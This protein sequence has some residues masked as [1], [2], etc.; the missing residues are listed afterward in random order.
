[1]KLLRFKCC[2][3]LIQAIVP[4][5]AVGELQRL[6]SIEDE[7]LALLI[8]RELLN[9]TIHCQAVTKNKAILLFVSPQN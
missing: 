7:Q 6:L 2:T 1:V 4:R 3:Q 5:K 9:V 8:G